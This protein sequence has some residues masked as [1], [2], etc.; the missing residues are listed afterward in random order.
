[1]RIGIVGPGRVTRRRTLPELRAIEGVEVVAV[2]SSSAASTARAAVELQIPRTHDRWQDLVADDAL[3]AVVIGTLPDLHCEV[4]VAALDAGKHV[5]CQARMA[6]DA[7]AAR[8]MLA[9][10]Q[11][12]PDLV[13]QVVPSP[14][15]LVVDPVVQR[16][17]AEGALG[18]L[19][20]VNVHWAKAEFV[21]PDAPLH[22]RHD[23]ARSGHNVIDLGLAYESLL[24]WVGPARSV[25]AAGAVHVPVRHDEVAGRDVAVEIPD[26]L[27]VLA[28]LP[29][30]ASAH[31]QVSTVTGHAPPPAFW[32]HG[33]EA[34]LWVGLE[35][36]ALALGRRSDAAL[37][38]LALTPDVAGAFRVE[39]DFVAAIRGERPVGPT[40]FADG[41]QYMEF[42]DAVHASRLSGHRET[43]HPL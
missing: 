16:L 3:D 6:T 36:P 38:P 8:A 20:A 9:A 14:R 1:M 17:L 18:R 37:Q 10:A 31:L 39:A 33:S 2:A 40:T 24:R 32:L 42:T 7:T 25:L 41:V 13:A 19:L 43:V 12:H 23:A 26:H 11:G 27:D 34:T 4:T 35:P 22:W 5:L 15:T 30:G 29:G 28:E 21:Q